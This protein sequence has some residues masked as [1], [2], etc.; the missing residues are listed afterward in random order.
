MHRHFF[1]GRAAVLAAVSTLS[2]LVNGPARA[3]QRGAA[4]TPAAPPGPP[5]TTAVAPHPSAAPGAL[6]PAAAPPL[7]GGVRGTCESGPL[8]F[9]PPPGGAPPRRRP[10]D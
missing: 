9:P 1:L 10:A 3:Q 2:L 8:R 4:P 6:P 7:C 5:S